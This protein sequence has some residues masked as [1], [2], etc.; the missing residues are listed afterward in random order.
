MSTP[1]KGSSPINLDEQE[2][3]ISSPVSGNA[4]ADRLDRQDAQIAALTTTIEAVLSKLTSLSYPQ[5]APHKGLDEKLELFSEELSEDSNTQRQ[6]YAA[7]NESVLDNLGA[8]RSNDAATRRESLA[9]QQGVAVGDLNEQQRRSADLSAGV[10]TIVERE[11]EKIQALFLGDG[12][13][14]KPG[15]TKKPHKIEGTNVI[16]VML[17]VD[18]LRRYSQTPG[19]INMF[20]DSWHHAFRE[21]PAFL[22]LVAFDKLPCTEE[23]E[24]D[25]VLG[26]SQSD[27]YVL[28]IKGRLFYHLVKPFDEW[29]DN[30]LS[31]KPA[32]P[33]TQWIKPGVTGLRSL[34][35][36]RVVR[37]LMMKTF[38]KTE[39]EYLTILF[40][41][42]KCECGEYD[43]KMADLKFEY[44]SSKPEDK[45][46]LRYAPKL[47]FFVE[48]IVA[49]VER[50]EKEHT[51]NVEA[52]Y[53][54]R[55]PVYYVKGGYPCIEKWLKNHLMEYPIFNFLITRALINMRKAGETKVYFKSFA[56]LMDSIKDEF[57][58]LK[59]KTE[60]L[61]NEKTEVS[62]FEQ[63]KKKNHER[64]VNSIMTD[65]SQPAGCRNVDSDDDCSSDS[66]DCANLSDSDDDCYS[67]QLAAMSGPPVK[68]PASKVCWGY[69]VNGGKLCKQGKG[70]AM[71]KSY[72]AAP[73]SKHDLNEN[74]EFLVKKA[75]ND[76]KALQQ[77]VANIKALQSGSGKSGLVSGKRDF[78]TK[79]V[80][81][82]LPPK[83][84]NFR[85]Q[86]ST[87]LKTKNQ[88][89]PKLSVNEL[90]SQ[91]K[92]FEDM[93]GEDCKTWVLAQL[94]R[95]KTKGVSEEAEDDSADS[96]S[97]EQ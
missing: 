39:L 77:K 82:R 55:K 8:L 12:E 44:S 78:Q 63:S 42:I 40:K 46:F 32:V 83:D 68:L 79:D 51:L 92:A 94:E 2:I 13:I 75:E 54:T 15:A 69:L 95:A 97:S 49:C 89:S 81:S 59:T 73:P 30:E 4:D 45:T 24:P 52:G 22:A 1:K 72:Q 86:K 23:F 14:Q 66:V 61:L 90:D 27:S 43:I 85:G 84:V 7:L 9:Y 58:G 17:A 93:S 36:S 57:N 91:V 48:V 11:V 65:Q 3:S 28:Y 31:R 19:T 16:D 50:M 34:E 67:S 74:S 76:I 53:H 56:S 33:D 35:Y 96:D 80:G 64:T 88:F 62:T 10:T 29:T 37:G 87:F 21:K 41:Y 18:A 20:A 26:G 71:C 47:M 38:P 6:S 5:T 25:R 70:C 60:Q